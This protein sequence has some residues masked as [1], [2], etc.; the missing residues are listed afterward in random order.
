MSN[1]GSLVV[2]LEANIAR[3]TSDMGKAA[4]IAE[5]RMAQIDKS[6]GIVNTA[7][8]SLGA[9][10]VVGLTLD[11]VK[12]KIQAVIAAA[13]G[14]QGLSERTGSTVE[15][16]SALAEVAKLSGTDT[17]S[18]ASGLQKLA[19][20]MVDAEHGGQ[21]SAEA[22][23]AIGIRIDEIR[24]KQPD[25]VFLLISNRLAEYADGAGKTA[26]A[27]QLLGKSGANLLPVAKDLADV[28]EY[29]VKVTLA[30]AVAADEYEKNLVRLDVAQEAIVKRIGLELVPVFNAVTEAMLESLKANNGLKKGIDSLAADGSI[31]AFAQDAAIAL[32]ILIETLTAVAKAAMAVA[33]S[34]Q[35]VYADSKFALQFLDATPG[36]A[37]DLIA[38]GTGPLKKALDERNAVL[39]SAN[40]AY[41]DAWNFDSRA[42]EKDLK[43]RFAAINA[44]AGAAASG[45]GREGRGGGATTASKRPGVNFDPTKGSSPAA[46]GPV[47]DPVRK[48]L[49]GK[50]KEQEAFIAAEKT[51]LQA[52]EQYLQSYYQ[53]EYLDASSYYGTKQTLIQDALR[54]E[55]EA[56]DKQS[57]A[58]A[59][60]IAQAKRDVDVQGARNKLAEVADKRAAAEIAAN[61]QL[62]DTVL[63]QAR[64]YREFDL[65][66]SAVAR[67]S[68]LANEQ[69]QFQIDLMGRSTLEVA[70]L[71]E[72]RRLQLALEE[73]LYAMR[74]KNLPQAE[75]DRAMLDTEEQKK[76]ALALIEESYLR[77]RTVAFGASEAF[78]KYAQ[79]AANVG[80][81]VEG[82]MSSAIKGMEDALVSFVTTGKLNFK[83]LANSI[84]AD[85]AR[86]LIQQN[87]TGPLAQMVQ[88]GMGGGGGGGGS[89]GFGGMVGSFLSGLFGRAGGGPVEAGGMYRVNELGPELLTVGGNQYLM[90]GSQAGSITP[91]G[92]SGASGGASGA[93]GGGHTIINN[94]TVGDVAS[95]AQVKAAVAASQRQM[96]AASRRSMSYGG[97]LA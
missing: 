44:A 78:R 47:D 42:M 86:I 95:M 89:S 92:G 3:F 22:F 33:R 2:S 53:Q 61:K 77:Q 20:T 4:S 41:S 46:T 76:A 55:L 26:L 84:I 83:S 85:I 45:W 51:Q 9:G 66:T 65:A 8:K 82:A 81:Q 28:G 49:E 87:I 35:V 62:T 57:A 34:F 74:G 73:R 91:N 32:V 1:L 29:Q 93:Q 21:K 27:M 40:D 17:E 88:G 24:G 30:Q 60:Y 56:Y 19:K 14:L 59:I 71:T 58:I 68:R 63:E 15:G 6:I 48:L 5:Q 25:E 52:R 54:V 64:A 69:A 50:L 18:L 94:F 23:R 96:F 97:A 72:E 37:Y 39:K 38:S 70:K 11:R 75:M 79:D 7:I 13:A 80:A 10:L 90:M 67:Q 43:Q 12:D 36:Q 31:S 16:L